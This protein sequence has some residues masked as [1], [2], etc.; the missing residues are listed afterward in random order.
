[1]EYPT[2]N[3]MGEIN[4]Y[5]E[6]TTNSCMLNIEVGGVDFEFDVPDDSYIMLDALSVD[7]ELESLY[8]PISFASSYNPIN[9]KPDNPSPDNPTPKPDEPDFPEPDEPEEPE[10]PTGTTA[11]YLTSN[12]ESITFQS[13][14]NVSESLKVESDK[15]V[16]KWSIE[17]HNYINFQVVQ[18]SSTICELRLYLY[19]DNNSEKWINSEFKV[20]AYYD[21]EQ[22]IVSEKTILI[23]VMGNKVIPIWKDEDYTQEV[24]GSIV[25]NIVN[26]NTNEVIYAG[27]AKNYPNEDEIKIRINKFVRGY[28]NSSFNEFGG[29]LNMLKG[30]SIPFNIIINNYIVATYTVYNDWGYTNTDSNVISEPI[31]NV[32]DSRQ[33]FVYSLYNRNGNSENIVYTT[34]DNPYYINVNS[35][36]QS[37]IADDLN[38]YENL[39]K[40]EV[41]DVVFD[42]KNTGCEWCLYYVNS[43]GG[44]DSLLIHGN[45]KKNDKIT[46]SYYSKQFNNSTI[47]FEK[48]KYNNIINSTFEL[49]T[50]WFTDEEQSK[51]FHLI[52]STEVYLHNLNTK[53]LYP[54]IITNT[55]VEYKT[56]TN[57]GKKKFNN[58]II[59]ES[60][61]SKIRL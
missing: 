2:I 29:K 48:T 37:L 9:P 34:N 61:Q 10:Q 19:T 56:F 13:D 26:A 38:K 41:G 39:N 7:E 17:K 6:Y 21:A 31:R 40:V 22:T 42:V 11:G 44:W 20:K 28:L 3:T 58:T 53:Q 18:T 52:E 45:S 46:S 23:A 8:I 54:V 49:H 47:E 14:S 25:F 12:R 4:V 36:Y 59:V 43:Y 60:S 51:L 1:M 5:M 35:N 57:N 32:L 27:N 30:Y 24:D 16:I 15:E 50:D 55:N 33:Y